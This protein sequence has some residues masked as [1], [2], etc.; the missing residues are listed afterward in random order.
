MICANCGHEIKEWIYDNEEKGFIHKNI[1]THC[2]MS[3]ICLV[4]D[5]H[6]NE[7]KSETR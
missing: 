1:G 7:P 6:C 4:N 2:S 3:K 5:C